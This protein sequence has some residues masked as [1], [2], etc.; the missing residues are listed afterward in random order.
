LR[1]ADMC[2]LSI[3]LRDRI[4]RTLDNCCVDWPT[5]G[6]RESSHS[7]FA[8]SNSNT[9]RSR[10]GPQTRT[11][12]AGAANDFASG[13]EF[14]PGRTSSTSPNVGE[15][16]PAADCQEFRV[17]PGGDPDSGESS[18][19][20]EFRAR[21]PPIESLIRSAAFSPGLGVTRGRSSRL[22]TSAGAA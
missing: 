18:D 8:S 19:R 14:K 22:V 9:L 15:F 17:R 3:E 4:A 10:R 1:A 7:P 6:R 2:R 11:R 21:P 13:P 5:L 12:G 20:Q 16:G